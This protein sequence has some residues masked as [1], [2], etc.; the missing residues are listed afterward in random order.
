[1]RRWRAE[2]AL[3][4]NTLVWGATFVVVKEALDQ[5]STLLFIAL[6]FSV[7]AVALWLLFLRRLGRASARQWRGAILCGI[8]LSLGYGL[9]T[10]GL[11]Y[12]SA[13][14]SAFI[15]GFSIALVPLMGAAVYRIRPRAME[16]AGV[17]LAMGGMAVMTLEGVSTGVA[18]GDLLTLGGAVA[19]AAHIL[20]VG[21]YSK[22]IRFELLSL[23]QV[24]VCAVLAT[25]LFWWAEVPRIAW[26]PGVAGAVLLTGLAATA[27]A[28]SI[29]SWAQQYTTPTRTALIFTLEPVFAWVTSYLLAGESL[30]GRAVAG[31]FLILGGIVL[32]EVKPGSPHL[33]P[34]E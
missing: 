4:F 17:S 27:L 21:H 1:M 19:F 7:A 12:T 30:S 6:R 31:A 16:L 32:V 28:F 13:P 5:V 20:A 3:V 23:V 29:Q 26:R 9:Q 24:A 2:L 11:R 10:F 15:T 14:K 22:E 18:L 34:S 25:G 33:H 8:F